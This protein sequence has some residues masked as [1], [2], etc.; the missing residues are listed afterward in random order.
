[1]VEGEILGDPDRKRHFMGIT[2]DE[3]LNLTGSA[4]GLGAHLSNSAPWS[5][6]LHDLSHQYS[7]ILE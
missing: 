7:L 4:N 1:M 5:V 2:T 6:H 3:G